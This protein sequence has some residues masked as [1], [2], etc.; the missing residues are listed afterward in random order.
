MTT[1]TAELSDSQLLRYSRDQEYEADRKGMQYARAAGY[2][3]MGLVQFLERLAQMEQRG[4]TIPWL[5]SH[6]GSQARADRLREMLGRE[7]R[8]GSQTR[9]GSLDARAR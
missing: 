9:S 3:P 4:T 8:S 5:S 6:P 7:R 1:C 2:D